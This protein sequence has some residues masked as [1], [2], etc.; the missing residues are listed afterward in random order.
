MALKKPG[1]MRMPVGAD[2]HVLVP[3]TSA[4]RHDVGIGGRIHTG[5]RANAVEEILLVRWA[6]ID[7]QLQ[8]GE[9][10]ISNQ[11]A[12]LPETGVENQQIAQAPNK[13]Q[14]GHQQNERQR[15]LRNDQPPP[16]SEAFAPAG[17]AAAARL[18]HRSRSNAGRTQSWRQSE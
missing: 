5:N 18:Q 9:I 1:V 6:A 8:F 11:E 10:K 13:Q 3:T 4:H 16:Q 17:H 14:R 7:R 12:V 2:Q 15:N